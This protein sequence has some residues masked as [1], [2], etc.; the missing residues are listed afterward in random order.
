MKHILTIEDLKFRAR[1]K[2]PKMFYDY[3]DS[4]SWE[5]KTYVANSNDFNNIKFRQRV[6][7]NVENRI[8]STE[9]FGQKV[10]MPI[11]LAPTGLCGMQHRD[12]EILAAQASEEFGVPFTLS[13][14]S[15][16]SIEDVAE[17]T[18]KPFW[19][20]LYVMRDKKFISNLLQRA[21]DCGCNVLQITMDLNILGQ[22]HADVRNGLSAPPKFNL[23]HIKQIL[24]KPR[25]AL[26][27]LRAKRHFFANVVG[28]ATGVTDNA[29]LWSWISEQ[30]DATFSWE[31]LDWIRNQWN[32][33]ILLK[34]ILDPEDAAMALKL[35]YDGIIVSNHGG[36]QLDGAP[37]TISALPGIVEEIDNKLEVYLDGGITSGQD[38]CKA[39]CLGAKGT[40]IGRAF[41]YGLGAGGKE[42]VTKCLEIIRNSLDETIAFLGETDVKNLDTKNIIYKNFY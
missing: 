26:G 17:K 18:T 19:F 3:A 27:M 36:R 40:L 8:L 31:D 34:G 42:G 10:S 1:K 9:F 4:G 12:G 21:Q 24:S 16:C 23:K 32:G 20:Q 30:F 28:H 37:S 22:R 41:L 29:T 39:L 6:G 38:L 11:A 25:W 5:Q 15:I 33:K 14:M 13:T 7:I 35:G 2:V